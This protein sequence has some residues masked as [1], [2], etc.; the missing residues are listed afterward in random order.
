MYAGL[1]SWL[2]L[3]IALDAHY[4]LPLMGVSLGLAVAFLGLSARRARGVAPL[5]LGAVAAALVLIGKFAAESPPAVYAGVALLLAATFWSRRRCRP[6]SLP[7]PR[8]VALRTA[9]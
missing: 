4:L 5:V 1:S 6:R 8:T 2:G 7:A 3:S 9:P